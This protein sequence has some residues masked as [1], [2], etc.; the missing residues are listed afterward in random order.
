ML[1]YQSYVYFPFKHHHQIVCTCPKT[2]AYFKLHSGSN[3]YGC[4]LEADILN[5]ER[6]TGTCFILNIFFVENGRF[7]VT[8]VTETDATEN[9]GHSSRRR[10]TEREKKENSE[11]VLQ[12]W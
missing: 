11:V 6:G 10:M 12:V 4:I 9:C 3:V 5:T 1:C 8:D 2:L 7:Y